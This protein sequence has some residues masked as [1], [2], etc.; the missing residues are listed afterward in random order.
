MLFRSRDSGEGFNSE[1]ARPLQPT[2]RPFQGLRWEGCLSWGGGR[3]GS[4]DE[5]SHSAKVTEKLVVP[6]PTLGTQDREHVCREKGMSSVPDTVSLKYL[7][8][9]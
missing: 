1:S 6:A 5:E 4:R 9:R 2:P 8:T 7:A 3:V